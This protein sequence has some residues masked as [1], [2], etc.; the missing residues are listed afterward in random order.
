MSDDCLLNPQGTF[1]ADLSWI[2][3]AG[4]C[5]SDMPFTDFG[6]TGCEHLWSWL[7]SLDRCTSYI[8]DF[9]RLLDA[10]LCDSVLR[11]SYRSSLRRP[12]PSCMTTNSG[13]G[14]ESLFSDPPSTAPASHR[15]NQY[16]RSHV[17]QG[18]RQR[19]KCTER[20]CFA[21]GFSYDCAWCGNLRRAQ[22]GNNC[23]YHD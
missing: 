1:Y 9:F 23:D 4:I 21:V 6:N 7:S 15:L 8:Y 13:G 3:P 19:G 16:R 22:H 10:S 12:W 5:T 2:K 11:V 20:Q 14:L 17:D 18:E